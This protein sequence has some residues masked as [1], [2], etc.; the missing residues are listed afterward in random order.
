[1]SSRSI[2]APRAADLLWFTAHCDLDELRAILHRVIAGL[3]PEQAHEALDEFFDEVQI[4]FD[5]TM[6]ASPSGRRTKLEG[7]PGERHR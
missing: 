5:V 4:A 6:E 1:L 2:S 7:S 3:P